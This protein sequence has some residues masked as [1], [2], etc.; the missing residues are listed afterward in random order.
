M[1]AQV[2][3]VVYISEQ[4]LTQEF[5]SPD[6]RVCDCLTMKYCNEADYHIS[7]HEPL[8]LCEQSTVKILSGTMKVALDCL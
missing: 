5:L 7:P 2:T 1:C 4:Y 8:K 6:L 3:S